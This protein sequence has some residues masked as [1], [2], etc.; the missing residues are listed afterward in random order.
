MG[1]PFR[2]DATV[3][4]KLEGVAKFFP[5]DTQA[6]K[7]VSL[8]LHRSESIALRGVSGSGKTTLLA[9]LGLLDTPTA[10]LYVLSGAQ[11]IRFSEKERTLARR[12]DLA[13][14]FQ[15]FHLVP[16]LTVLENVAEGLRIAGLSL[17]ERTERAREALI[18]VGLS[19]RLRAMPATLSGGEQQRV[20]VARAVARTP[21]LLLCDE[22]TGNL[23]SGSSQVVLDTILAAKEVGACVVIATHDE[24]VAR[25][26]EREV[27]VSD[28]RIVEVR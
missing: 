22:P 28:G 7:D 4:A 5:P 10:G 23:D 19:H 25:Q 8:T 27:H 2:A 11:T 26:C 12:R 9:I 15:A 16:H 21:K 17:F 1:E 14:I 3:V 24:T 6:L 13:F 20:A 18:I